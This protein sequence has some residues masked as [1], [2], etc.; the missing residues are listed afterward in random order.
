MTFDDLR[1]CLADSLGLEI[2][3][4]GPQAR[5][6]DDLGVD[7]LAMHA[8]LIDIE[9]AGGGIPAPDALECV[10]TVSDLFAAVTAAT[11]P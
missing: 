3:E 10:I 7:S 11:V 8:L 1:C 4:F 6:V 9:E 2:A 5:L